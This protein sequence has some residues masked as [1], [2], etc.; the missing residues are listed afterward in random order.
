[1]VSW[2]AIKVRTRAELLV[3]SFLRDKCQETFV[4]TFVECRQYSDRVTRVKAALFPGYLFCRF[5]SDRRL[6]I[7]QSPGVQHVVGDSKGPIPVDH[8]EIDALQRVIAGSIA[9]QPWPF[10]RT[11]D[12]VRIQYGSFTGVEGILLSEKGAD[13]LILSVQLLQRSVAVQMDRSWV[14]PTC[15][16]AVTTWDSGQRSRCRAEPAPSACAR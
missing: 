3:E 10:L 7:L 5:D 4:P 13:L 8:A 9:V 14:R 12:R 1:M 11:G 2:Y 16:P 15:T 6:P